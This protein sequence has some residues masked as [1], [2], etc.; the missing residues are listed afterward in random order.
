LCARKRTIVTWSTQNKLTF[1]KKSSIC[2]KKQNKRARAHSVV[3][4]EPVPQF[5]AFFEYNLARNGL[6]HLVQ[7]R[8]TVAVRYPGRGNYTVVVPKRGIWGTAGI[9]GANID[10]GI[11]NE[12]AYEVLAASGEALDEVLGAAHVDLLKVDV[13]G[14]EPDVLAV[15]LR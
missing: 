13:E 2:P 5:R 8:P 10:A 15:R 9:D 7:V 1:P 14:Y 3:A 11:D 6:T 4:F 12:G